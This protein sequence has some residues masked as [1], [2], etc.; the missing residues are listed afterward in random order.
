[1][2]WTIGQIYPSEQFHWYQ[3]VPNFTIMLPLVQ[4]VQVNKKYQFVLKC[5]WTMCMCTNNYTLFTKI[6]KSTHTFRKGQRKKKKKHF[7]PEY[8]SRTEARRKE[9]RN[10]CRS[11]SQWILILRSRNAAA[12]KHLVVGV[13]MTNISYRM[14]ENFILT[15]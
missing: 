15:N 10:M 8:E 9:M 2:V 1:M 3:K 4:K 6:V 11:V 13:Y 5:M 14:R 12:P 7:V